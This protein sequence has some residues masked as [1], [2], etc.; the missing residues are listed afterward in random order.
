MYTFG[1]TSAYN[2]IPNPEGSRIRR[3]QVL[4]FFFALNH[5]SILELPEKLGWNHHAILLWSQF[6]ISLL[7]FLAFPE[8]T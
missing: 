7:W 3:F 2:Q 8:T 1:E 6:S 5:Y 4:K